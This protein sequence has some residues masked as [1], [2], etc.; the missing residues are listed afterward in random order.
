MRRMLDAIGGGP[1]AIIPLLERM[2]RTR[3]N[4]EFLATLHKESL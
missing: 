1:D 4:K 2:A 3:S